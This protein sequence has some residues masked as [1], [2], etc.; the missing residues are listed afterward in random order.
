MKFSVSSI[1]LLFGTL[2]LAAGLAAPSFGQSNLIPA[3]TGSAAYKQWKAE[4]DAWENNYSQWQKRYVK[5]QEEQAR[6]DDGFLLSIG[7]G[8]SPMRMDTRFSGGNVTDFPD[9]PPFPDVSLRGLGL[10]VD[11]RMGWLVEND[12]YLK[13]YWYGDDELHD[14]LFLTFDIITRSTPYPQWRFAE[15]DSANTDTFLR[16]IFVMDLIVGPGMTYLIYPYRISFSSTVGF[17]LLGIQGENGSI[18]SQIG[19]AFSARVAQEWVVK[20]NWRSGIAISYGIAQ[21]INPRR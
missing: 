14:Q 10:A 21:S 6:L 13:D 18:R 7:V 19:P 15:N 12:P 9:R 8:P 4:H 11:A 17:G 16:P 5:W 20:E 3:D 1:Q 2:V